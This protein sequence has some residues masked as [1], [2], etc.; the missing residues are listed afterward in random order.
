MQE[1]LFKI[2]FQ[3]DTG[4]VSS[5]PS[6]FRGALSGAGYVTAEIQV[7]KQGHF[8]KAEVE[9]MAEALPAYAGATYSANLKV[10]SSQEEADHA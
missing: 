9:Q 10:V 6:A 5:L 7:R 1:V 2:F 4:D 3:S 8:S